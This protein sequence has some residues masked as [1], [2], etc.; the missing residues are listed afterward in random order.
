[1]S[2]TAHDAVIVTVSLDLDGHPDV[3]AF[4]R[5]MPP[6]Y[7]R[8]VHGPIPGAI[9]NYVTWVFAPDGSHKG[10]P[11]ADAA[12]E[13]RRQFIELWEPGRASLVEVRFGGDFGRDHDPV[14]TRFMAGP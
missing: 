7:R 6:E 13:W 11:E 1:M 3:Q 14:F 4:K 10:R 8:L 9:N 5:S 12:Y 2:Y